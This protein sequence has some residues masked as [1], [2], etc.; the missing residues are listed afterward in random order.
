MDDL[1]TIPSQRLFSQIKSLTEFPIMCYTTCDPRRRT[2]MFCNL[3]KNI[4][5]KKIKLNYTFLCF[6]RSTTINEKVGKKEHMKI[7]IE[8]LAKDDELD[9]LARLRLIIDTN[10]SAEDDI[11]RIARKTNLKLKIDHS[12]HRLSDVKQA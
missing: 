3:I 11:Y 5:Q 8:F 12:H 4:P 10:Q 6:I 2:M 1:G 7:V 9:C